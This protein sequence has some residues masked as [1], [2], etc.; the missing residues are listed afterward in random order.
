MSGIGK[1]VAELGGVGEIC[2][3]EHL[4]KGPQICLW[5][6]KFVCGI[7]TFGIWNLFAWSE[8]QLAQVSPITL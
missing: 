5:C 4:L 2:W 3:V 6:C 7:G 8:G 1:A